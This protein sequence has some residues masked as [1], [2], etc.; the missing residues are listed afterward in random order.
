MKTVCDFLCSALKKHVRTFLFLV[1]VS[2]FIFSFS[3]Y[4]KEPVKK[5]EKKNS[6]EGLKELIPANCDVVTVFDFGVLKGSAGAIAAFTESIRSNLMMYMPSS[7]DPYD[8]SAAPGAAIYAGNEKTGF[9][10]FSVPL[11]QKKF[12][13]LVRKNAGKFTETKLNGRTFYTGTFMQGAAKDTGKGSFIFTFITPDIVAI[14]E[15]RRSSRN[16]LIASLNAR[17]GISPSMEKLLSIRRKEAFIYGGIHMNRIEKRV[18]RF[19]PGSAGLRDASFDVCLTP[20][21][22]LSMEMIIEADSQETAQS[23]GMVLSSY[24]MLLAGLLQSAEANAAREAGKAVKLTPPDQ[25]VNVRI[26]NTLVKLAMDL[27]AELIQTLGAFAVMTG[28]AGK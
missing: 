5:V 7:A 20:R 15:N 9:V 10:L 12:I 22:T 4:G 18:A 25:L 14:T 8:S 3:V 16:M 19:F 2:L 28:M 13:D 6:I 26:E 23:L 17:K 27:P 21:K 11:P 1:S 24:K